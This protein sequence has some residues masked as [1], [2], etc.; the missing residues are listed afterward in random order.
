TSNPNAFTPSITKYRTA[1]S[2]QSL[3]KEIRRR[4]SSLSRTTT[5]SKPAWCAM[6]G[7][8]NSGSRFQ[9]FWSDAML[10]VREIALTVVGMVTLGG[11]G[12]FGYDR[13][14]RD[15]AAAPM[16]AE[17]RVSEREEGSGC[18]VKFKPGKPFAD[19]HGIKAEMAHE[20][21]W[22]PRIVVDG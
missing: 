13:L 17:Q 20:V 19:F 6:A 2:N 14:T 21:E 10:P 22:Q 8:G 4:W 18:V 9:R 15:K 3:S 5:R 16:V 7:N 12:W 11:I 1:K